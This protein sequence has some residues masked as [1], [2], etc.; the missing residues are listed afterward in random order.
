MY[1]EYTDDCVTSPAAYPAAICA[2]LKPLSKNTAEKFSPALIQTNDYPT[3]NVGVLIKELRKSDTFYR[4]IK[5]IHTVHNISD[6][7]EY[8]LFSILVSFLSRKQIEVL[9][10][11]SE[12]SV[13]LNLIRQ[14]HKNEYKFSDSLSVLK[15]ID[16]HC[17]ELIN[18]KD[19]NFELLMCILKEKFLDKD[20]KYYSMTK[21]IINCCDKWITVS[22][23]MYNDLIT[24]KY[25]AFIE[26]YFEKNKEKGHAILS[27]ISSEKYNPEN[28]E[29]IKFPY[30][31]KNFLSEKQKNKLYLQKEFSLTNIADNKVNAEFFTDYQNKTIL[32]SLSKNKDAITLLFAGRNDEIKGFKIIKELIPCMLEKHSN[33]QIIITGKGIIEENK[34]YLNSYK[35]KKFQNSGKLLVIDDFVNI[36]QFFAASDLFLLPS[37][38]ESCALT[39]MQAM[40]YG[41]IP[42]ASLTGCV[43]EI[44]IS[45][46]ENIQKANGF[47]VKES[48]YKNPSALELYKNAIEDALKFFSSNTKIK[49]TLIANAMCCDTGWNEEKIS[50]Y[51]DLFYSLGEM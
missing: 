24:N 15:Y 10:N 49:D 48:L 32:G 43:N 31:S 37:Y 23:S 38:I 42:V 11:D 51:K 25:N 46:D 39:V 5:L 36:K 13:I 7:G 19:K 29:E 40:R 9:C 17:D 1:K 20:S 16:L 14:E 44:I 33:I 3:A 47:K 4:N 18:N 26:S 28:K 35:L 6:T 2:L 41:A 22:E 21:E 27:G 30:N 8:G 50:K 34:N 12:I 45:P